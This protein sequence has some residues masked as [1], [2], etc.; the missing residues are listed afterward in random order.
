MQEDFELEKSEKK[1]FSHEKKRILSLVIAFVLVIAVSVLLTFSLTVNYFL[2]EN[3]GEYGKFAVL[4]Q[5]IDKYSYYEPDYDAMM[6]A[7]LK[8]YVSRTG[9]RYAEY[10]NA[11][12]FKA[13]NEDNEGRF[14]G[15]GVTITVADVIYL[16]NTCA[17]L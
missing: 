1:S 12:D 7:A 8:A 15:I 13:L 16:D 3:N 17:M 14:V 9:D 10:Y 4:K 11:E 6:D 2:S 5:Y